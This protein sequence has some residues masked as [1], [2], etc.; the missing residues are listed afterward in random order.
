MQYLLPEKWRMYFFQKQSN[1]LIVRKRKNKT[2]K[3]HKDD[4]EKFKYWQVVKNVFVS[5]L[6]YMVTQEPLCT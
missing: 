1:R 2:L 4:V 6:I 5:V 3:M